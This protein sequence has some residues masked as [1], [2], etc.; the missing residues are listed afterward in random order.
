MRI[1]RA[2]GLDQYREEQVDMARSGGRPRR[3][4]EWWARWRERRG[5]EAAPASGS[6]APVE[7]A[8]KGAVQ[9][10]HAVEDSE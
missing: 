5:A 4:A 7:L 1:I 8:G 9:Q 10:S 3:S 2:G 6:S